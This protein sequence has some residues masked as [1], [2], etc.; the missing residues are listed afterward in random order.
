MD[1]LLVKLESSSLG[2]RIGGCYAG[3]ITYAG[4]LI[5]LSP[6]RSA[7]Q[8]MLDLCVSHITYCGFNFNVKISIC[9][10]FG[11]TTDACTNLSLFLYNLYL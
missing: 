8:K 4:D 7:L 6:T 2:S 1:S 5:L 3:A 9:Y 10:M 11:R